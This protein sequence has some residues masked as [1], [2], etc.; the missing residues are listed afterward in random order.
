MPKRTRRTHTPSFKAKVA[1]AAIRGDGTIAD[2]AARFEVH[3]NQIQSWKKR[4]LERG[5]DVFARSHSTGSERHD[6]HVKTLQSKIGELLIEKDFLSK[7][8][9][10]GL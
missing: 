2:L 8:L 4:M 7:A 10:R 5:E 6:E 9:G 3:P 1:F